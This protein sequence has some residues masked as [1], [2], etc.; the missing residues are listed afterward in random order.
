[1]KFPF[2]FVR[3]LKR[4]RELGNSS[5]YI[6]SP[7][8]LTIDSF[9]DVLRET[10]IVHLVVGVDLAFAKVRNRF[11]YV[12]RGSIV[13]PSDAVE[14]FTGCVILVSL[15]SIAVMRYY[16]THDECFQVIV[17]ASILSFVISRVVGFF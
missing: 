6:G 16:A 1:M 12:I 3:C 2:L 13:V 14:R 11:L 15:K 9:V 17:V 10:D 8:F 7:V 5:V 4:P